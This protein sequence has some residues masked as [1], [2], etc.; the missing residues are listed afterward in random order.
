M[1][2]DWSP[3]RGP[4]LWGDLRHD[5]LPS[6]V[7]FLV[8][9]PLCM[10]IAIASGAPVAA[11][12]VTGILG[13]IVV[14]L[15]G[16]S[17]L[18]V[19]GP[20]AGLT[21]IV[22]GI[23][24]QHGLEMLALAVFGAGVCQ[25]IAGTARVGQ[26]FRAVAPAVVQGML[27]GIGILI[28]AS[29]FHVMF[30]DAPKSNG[31]KNLTAIPETLA[32]GLAFLP[33]GEETDRRT[34][35][36]TLQELRN[37]AERQNLL[38]KEVAKLAAPPTKDNGAAP[39]DDRIK[40]LHGR[41]SEITRELTALQQRTQ[42][43][44]W[45]PVGE[46]PDAAV[47][48]G[49]SLAGAVASA[50]AAMQAVGDG[51]PAQAEQTTRAASA[52][53]EETLGTLR[54][55]DVAGKLGLATLAVILAWGSLKKTVLGV[56]PA[57]LVAVV[58][59][60]VLG[61]AFTLPIFFVDVPDNLW[62]DLRFAAPQKVLEMDWGVLATAVV[63]LAV[64]ASAETLL[65]A[66]AVDQMHRGPR[67]RYDRELFAQG[68]GNA[69]AGWFG[70]LPMTGVIVRSAANVQAG[71]RSRWS[72][73]L[74]G[75][76]LLVFVVFLG[77][78]LRLIPTSALAAILV[79]TGY[80]LMN[81]KVAKEMQRYGRGELFVYIATTASVVLIDLLSGVIIGIVLSALKLLIRFAKL[82]MSYELR[83]DGETADL[84]LRGA[85][86][87]LKLPMLAAQL[88]EVPSDVELHV[89]IDELTEIDH[90]C[91]ELLMNWR[92][93]HE[94]QGGRLVL[95]WERLRFTCGAVYGQPQAVGH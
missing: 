34:H 61:M 2:R 21:V 74:H 33:M 56:V 67:T 11:G 52:A 31:W 50:E 18:Q 80:K 54:R 15:L 40:P 36:Q 63:T 1:K 60:V 37:L 89:H 24:Q 28:F 59:A 82:D 85:A 8:A 81:F 86:V 9:L 19:S 16:G 12:L 71:A 68:L 44:D 79:L 87:F 57:Q 26:W 84:H 13:G 14:G 83:P 88:E 51:K 41:Q 25:M 73:V 92:K 76:W 70:G 39:A 90:A 4:T 58:A 55:F 66:T 77:Q 38:A 93:Q 3:S 46:N 43:D 95:D 32:K 27:S 62:A 6:F 94:A 72:A 69:L 42:A 65:C 22:Y 47:T 75:A 29:Q 45:R 7:V 35:Q 91:F 10:G 64:V 53:V 30:D 49:E 78:L 48:F 5:I 20:A 23:V 17:P